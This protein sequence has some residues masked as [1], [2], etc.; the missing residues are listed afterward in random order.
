MKIDCDW[1]GKKN[2][3]A[4]ING[5]KFYMDAT[6]PF[7]DGSVST[8]KELVLAALCGCKGMDVIGLLQKNKQKPEKFKIEAEANLS[9]SQPYELTDIKLKYFINGLCDPEKVTEAVKLSQDTNIAF[10]ISLNGRHLALGKSE[11]DTD[12]L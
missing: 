8:P 5:F 1:N 11:L 6:L 2:F 4:S 10:D 7:S 9:S 12:L 3:V